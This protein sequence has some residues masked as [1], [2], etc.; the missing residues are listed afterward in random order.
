MYKSIHQYVHG[1]GSRKNQHVG[2]LLA[3][4]D[5]EDGPVIVTGSKVNLTHGDKF[6]PET[7]LGIAWDRQTTVERGRP[8]RIASSMEKDLKRFKDRCKRYF[9]T[10]DIHI[11]VV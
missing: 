1:R 2:V 9:R 3:V 7:A 6:N 11:P 10:D 5:K 8:N 4:R